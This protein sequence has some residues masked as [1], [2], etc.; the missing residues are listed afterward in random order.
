MEG[1]K[2]TQMLEVFGV[3]FG[4]LPFRFDLSSGMPFAVMG[5]IVFPKPVTP[6]EYQSPAT[7]FPLPPTAAG[8]IPKRSRSTPQLNSNQDCTGTHVS[9]GKAVKTRPRTL[10]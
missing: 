1:E 7:P 6:K 8:R 10:H 9:A 5:V 2:K 3:H 4:L